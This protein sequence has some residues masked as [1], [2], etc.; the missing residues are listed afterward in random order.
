MAAKRISKDTAFRQH[1][2]GGTV[3]LSHSQ[4]GFPRLLFSF[5]TEGCDKPKKTAYSSLVAKLRTATA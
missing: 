5:V 4:S 2:S 3:P 1:H